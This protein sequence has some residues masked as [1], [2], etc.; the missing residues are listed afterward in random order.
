MPGEDVFIE[1]QVSSIANSSHR[2]QA[3]IGDNAMDRDLM[4]LIKHF[5]ASPTD[6]FLKRHNEAHITFCDNID[7]W[8]EAQVQQMRTTFAS[9]ANRM[10]ESIKFLN[11]IRDDV[12]AH[13]SACGSAMA[14]LSSDEC[15]FDESMKSRLSTLPSQEYLLFC[16]IVG[17]H[18]TL[19]TEEPGN[20][21]ACIQLLAI[22]AACEM[23]DWAS[24]WW[25]NTATNSGLPKRSA[26]YLNGLLCGEI[27]QLL[28][29]EEEEVEL[30]ES[31]ELVGESL[32][33][34]MAQAIGKSR[35][36]LQFGEAT[37]GTP[38]R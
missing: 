18:W 5:N 1:S 17:C 23:N 35:Q 30:T 21:A 20:K 29:A 11:V 16:G 38:P 3:F 22:N 31:G 19:V 27:E 24:L 14:A 15:P 8:Y 6:T 4:R 32:W 2:A 33:V 34:I 26:A 7:R 10:D 13:F 25:N 36:L 28:D 9:D 37:P 12:Y